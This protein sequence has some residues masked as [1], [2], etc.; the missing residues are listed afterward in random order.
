MLKID[1]G[2]KARYPDLH[3]TAVEIAGV[4][5]CR[6]SE[7]L[8]RIANEV[9]RRVREGF[10]LE[11]LRNYDVFRAY[12]DFFW[13]LNIDPTKV[14]PASEALVRRVLQGK[15]IP[16]INTL[17]DAYNLA[18]IETGIA[19]AAFDSDRVVGEA[20]LRWA[21]RG[22]KFKG[23]GVPFEKELDGREL[24]LA[25]AEKVIAIYPYRD[26]EGTKITFETRNVLLVICGVPGVTLE[27]MREAEEKAI[28]YVTGVCGGAVATRVHV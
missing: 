11:E 18:S 8:R 10:N 21:K 4:K 14:R 7:K 6:S 23:I 16:S 20:V 22:E 9:Y 1:D 15:E 2:V 3:A 28:E 26:S 24:V 5:V 25:D 27:R 17:V 13:K 19:L 12:R